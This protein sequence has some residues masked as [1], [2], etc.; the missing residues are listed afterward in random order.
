M[1]DKP[2]SEICHCHLTKHGFIFVN[3]QKLNLK[4]VHLQ[5]GNDNNFQ[6]LFRVE[7]TDNS[8]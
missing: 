2:G 4:F 8:K 5:N 3:P 7:I 6:K 1:S